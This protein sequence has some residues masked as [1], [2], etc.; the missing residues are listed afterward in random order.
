MEKYYSNE[1]PERVVTN[2]PRRT[3][4]YGAY[5]VGEEELQQ[6]WD[7]LNKEIEGA[8]S[9]PDEAFREFHKYAYYQVEIP[10][11]QWTR[12]GIINAIIRDKYPVDVMEAI[13]NNMAAVNAAFMQTLVTDGIIAATKYLKDSVDQERSN[14]FKEMQDWR[15]MAKQVASE[16]IKPN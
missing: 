2:P 12:D 8:P 15:Q 1:I 13:T 5:E 10:M 16:I 6:K 7:E 4:T 9:T 3:L 14:Q 11:G